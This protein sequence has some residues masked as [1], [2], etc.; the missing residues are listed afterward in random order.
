MIDMSTSSNNDA[1]FFQNKKCKCGKK[2]EVYISES[3]NNSGKLYFKCENKGCDYFAWG[4]PPTGNGSNIQKSGYDYDFARNNEV[5]NILERL[6]AKQRER[7]YQI[8]DVDNHSDGWFYHASG[9]P[10]VNLYLY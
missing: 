7:S 6:D 2:E 10:Q 1:G 4:V 8:H 9:A 3:E 5:M